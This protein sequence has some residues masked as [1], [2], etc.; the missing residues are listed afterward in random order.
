VRGA[1]LEGGADPDSV[2]AEGADVLELFGKALEI[3]PGVVRVLP[4][5]D[6]A[7]VTRRA[8]A[9]HLEHHVVDD[10]VV[11]RRG[12]VRRRGGAERRERLEP[13]PFPAAEDEAIDGGRRSREPDP[14]ELADGFRRFDLQWGPVRAEDR[15]L[16]E[17]RDDRPTS[18][19]GARDRGG[20]ADVG[21]EGGRGDEEGCGEDEAAH[22]GSSGA[23]GIL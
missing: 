6:L 19:F 5:L 11:V 1:R 14:R 7:V 4:P 21:R 15:L 8:V 17:G 23:D 2:R 20:E 3:A 9:K 12:D 10:E 22:R 13:V 18:R 16:G